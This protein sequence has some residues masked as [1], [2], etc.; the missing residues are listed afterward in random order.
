MN[1]SEKIRIG[2]EYVMCWDL[3]ESGFE[4]HIVP[5]DAKVCQFVVKIPAVGEPTFTKIGVELDAANAKAAELVQAGLL[6]SKYLDRMLEAERL[7]R[8]NEKADAVQILDGRLSELQMEAQRLA[9][10]K[11][12]IE[13]ELS[14][15][16]KPVV[17]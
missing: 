16:V 14:T 1:E 12:Q 3:T 17:R 9:E 10:E 4:L 13:R 11:L 15:T 8:Y 7:A 6:D 5:I 2:D